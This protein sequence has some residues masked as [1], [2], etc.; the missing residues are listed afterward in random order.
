MLGFL[1]G[2]KNVKNIE[3]GRLKLHLSIFLF[4]NVKKR[5][6]YV[7]FFKIP[8]TKCELQNKGRNIQNKG[9]IKFQEKTF[10]PYVLSS[11]KR[12]KF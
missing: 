9:S 5:G 4:Y 3:I 12:E 1:K 7:F 10:H 2:D 11:S 6:M 8:K